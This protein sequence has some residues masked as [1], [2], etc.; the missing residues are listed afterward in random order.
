MTYV[1]E[2]SLAKA[3]Y[4][5]INITTFMQCVHSLTN[6]GDKETAVRLNTGDLTYVKGLGHGLTDSHMKEKKE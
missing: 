6:Q 5:A 1:E 3:T 2:L 4:S